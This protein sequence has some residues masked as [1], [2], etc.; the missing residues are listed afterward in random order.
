MLIPKKVKHR[1]WQSRRN[2]RMQGRPATRG[3]E[4]AFGS[5]GL[6]STTYHRIRSNQ[7]EAARRVISRSVGKT[8]KVWIRIFPDMPVTK[9]PPEVKLGKG[10]GDPVGYCTPVEPGRIV[11]EVDGVDSEIARKALRKAGLKLP[12]QTKVISRE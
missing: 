8:A 2:K 12:V 9:K 11:F 5:H 1:K 3:T 6:K 7:I 10:K 4:L